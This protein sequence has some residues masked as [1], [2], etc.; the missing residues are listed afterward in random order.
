LNREINSTEKIADEDVK[1]TAPRPA[2][3]A[4]RWDG[5]DEDDDIKVQIFNKQIE[6][7]LEEG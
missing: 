7:Q 6:D 4:N 5:E 2:A 1:P 3:A